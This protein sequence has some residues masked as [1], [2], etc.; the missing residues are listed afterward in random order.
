[1]VWVLF[2]ILLFVFFRIFRLAFASVVISI[3]GF[4]F[5]LGSSSVDGKYSTILTII[6]V[7]L[8]GASFYFRGKVK[9]QK[10]LKVQK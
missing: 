5:I 10:N 9:E 3:L 1:M 8:V 6:G 7:V 4:G 2:V